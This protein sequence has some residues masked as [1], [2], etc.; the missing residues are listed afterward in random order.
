M[1]RDLSPETGGPVA[2]IHG[3]SAAQR[4][5]GHDVRVVATDFGLPE[6][7]ELL[8]GYEVVACT[9]AAWR[10]APALAELLSERIAWCDVVHIHTIWEYPSLLAARLARRAGKPFLMR[11]CGMLDAW[12]MTQGSL[13]KR[14]YLGLFGRTLFSP[15]CTVH[16]TTHAEQRKSRPPCAPDSIVIEN[17]IAEQAM[18]EH[19]PEPFFARFPELRGQRIVLFLSR[20]HAKKRPDI[21]I[22][23][24]AAVAGRY[25][26]AVLV[27]AGPCGDDYRRELEALAYTEGI[28]GRLHFTGMLQ[29]EVLYAAYRAAGM[30][31]LPSMQEN[32]GIAVAEAMAAGCPV[33]ISEN[34]DIRSYIEE[35]DAGIVCPVDA[36]V[37]ASA[38]DRIFSMPNLAHRVG[39][40]GRKVAQEY[41][42]WERAADRLDQA[43]KKLMQ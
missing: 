1:I 29:D 22:C 35:A 34:V 24:F 8:A 4:Q 13:K 21:A 12:S 23:A 43:Y 7:A 2:A 37:F 25:P 10:Y 18:A 6:G 16:Y 36:D 39:V 9:R 32:F 38:L 3:L 28:A 14:L 26:D 11:P 41:F 20:V 33:I 19:D 17:G 27:L 42:T 30:F 5:L 40:N 15:P 31:L